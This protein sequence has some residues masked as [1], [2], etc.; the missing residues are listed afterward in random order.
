MKTLESHQLCAVA[1][2]NMT[3]ENS[4]EGAEKSAKAEHVVTL[5]MMFKTVCP[6]LVTGRTAQQ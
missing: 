3:S 5:I 1:L 4:R 6:R 2:F